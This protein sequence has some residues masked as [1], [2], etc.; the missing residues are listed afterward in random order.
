M[1]NDHLEQFTL[2]LA[3]IL[4]CIKKLKDNRMNIYGLRSSHV[5]VLYVLGRAPEGLTPAELAEAGDVDKALISRVVAELTE[6]GFVTSINEGGR[7]YKARLRLTSSGEELSVYI[8]TAVA[9]IQQQ[10]SGNIPKEDLEGFYRTLF[11][12]KTNFHR[13]VDADK[14]E[15]AL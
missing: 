10:V 4:K 12:L 14:S 11:A 1:Y 8:A 6:K 7:R 15:S 5:I 2:T 3:D 13:L 9:E